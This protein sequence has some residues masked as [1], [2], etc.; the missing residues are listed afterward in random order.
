M[1]K[2]LLLD[3]YIRDDLCVDLFAKIEREVDVASIRHAGTRIWP[4]IKLSVYQQAFNPDKPF[5]VFRRERVQ[6]VRIARDAAAYEAMR[7]GAGRTD[8]LFFCL[9]HEYSPTP[10]GLHENRYVDPLIDAFAGERSFLKFEFEEAGTPGSFP[11]KTPSVFWQHLESREDIPSARLEPIENFGPVREAVREAF[12]MDLDE[13]LFQQQMEIVNAYADE[14]ANMLDILQPGAAF[15]VSYYHMIGMSLIKA[16]R[17]LG[18]PSVDI[19]HGAQS[20]HPFYSPLG[21]VP[22]GGWDFYPD[23]F[24]VWGENEAEN[25]A[26]GV[27]PQG[28]SAHRPVVGGNLWFD[29]FDKEDGFEASEE[30][31]ALDRAVAGRERVILTALPRVANGVP[32]YLLEALAASPEGW[33]WLFRQHPYHKDREGDVRLMLPPEL[34]EKVESRAAN[35]LPLPALLKRSTNFVTGCSSSLYEALCLGT[36]SVLTHL[37]GAFYFKEFLASGMVDIAR[38]APEL[39]QALDGSP[40]R[41]AT[42]ASFRPYLNNRGRAKAALDRILLPRAAGPAGELP[43]PS[44]RDAAFSAPAMN[45][46]PWG[47][48]ACVSEAKRNS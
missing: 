24:W 47:G 21:L 5:L 23:F 12:G 4:L 11:R 48:P 8:A 14:F 6:R 39:I 45:A 36:H 34:A 25:I 44:I 29:G 1:P 33:L 26:G 22:E 13:R 2:E 31:R 15:L 9:L 18:I 30:M 16:C 43:A 38:T 7:N 42:L 20:M 37:R 28:R 40:D 10:G 17:R 3:G 27:L 32:E 46:R 41:G 35:S 19:Q